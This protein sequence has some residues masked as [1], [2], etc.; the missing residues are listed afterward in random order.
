[1]R[2]AGS[3]AILG[4]ERSLGVLCTVPTCALQPDLRGAVRPE[5]T[6]CFNKRVWG[7]KAGTGFGVSGSCI[8]RCFELELLWGFKSRDS[9]HLR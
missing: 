1:M 9:P 4:K 6:L 3:A 2:Q 5:N 7:A 8:L